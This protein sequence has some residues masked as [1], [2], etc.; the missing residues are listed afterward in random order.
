MDFDSLATTYALH[1]VDDAPVF[2]ERKDEILLELAL[3]NRFWNGTNPSKII[4]REEWNLVLGRIKSF[5]E[6]R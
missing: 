4:S 5:L 2:A 3:Q 1:N 6:V